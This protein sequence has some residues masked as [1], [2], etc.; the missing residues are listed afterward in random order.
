MSILYLLI[1]MAL[2]LMGVAV[3]A[4]IWAVKT[5]QFDDLEGPAHRILMDDDDPRIP[6][7]AGREPPQDGPKNS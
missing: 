5:G 1:P 2:V 7:A 4:F 6:T 3:G